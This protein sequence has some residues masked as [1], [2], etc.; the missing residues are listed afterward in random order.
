MC[1]QRLLNS[2]LLAAFQGWREAAC[3]LRD[4]HLRMQKAAVHFLNQRLA[5][6]FLTWRA[7]S[8]EALMGAAK[9][10]HA[11]GH[12]LHGTLA[13]VFSAWRECARFRAYSRPIISGES[14][15]C[16]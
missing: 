13:K 6:S 1:L 14:A 9:L 8:E 11:V 7:A 15:A 5:I 16:T 2:R 10:E 12:W 4:K 3:E